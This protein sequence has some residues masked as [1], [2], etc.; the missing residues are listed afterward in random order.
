MAGK[1]NKDAYDKLKKMKAIGIENAIS[2]TRIKQEFNKGEQAGLE[3]LL[4]G[5]R[6]KTFKKNNE[7]Y[8]YIEPPAID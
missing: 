8:Y 3:R 2:E 7:T 4:Q 5:K 1:Q 6:I